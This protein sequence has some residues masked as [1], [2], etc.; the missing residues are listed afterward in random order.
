MGLLAAGRNGKSENLELDSYLSFHKLHL[1]S[2]QTGRPRSLFYSKYCNSRNGLE[3]S[4]TNPAGGNDAHTVPVDHPHSNLLMTK[5]TCMS[6][7]GR[8]SGFHLNQV[9]KCVI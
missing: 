7:T 2:L 9:I 3:S 5:G 4:D 6:A 1:K 8:V